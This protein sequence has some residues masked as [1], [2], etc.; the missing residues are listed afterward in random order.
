MDCIDFG[1]ADLVASVEIEYFG[2]SGRLLILCILA[3]YS[4]YSVFDLNFELIFGTF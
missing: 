1:S 4:V 2:A 3:L